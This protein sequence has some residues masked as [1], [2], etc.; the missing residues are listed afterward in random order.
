[1]TPSLNNFLTFFFFSLFVSRCMIGTLAL[2]GW[3]GSVPFR[4][5]EDWHPVVQLCLLESFHSELQGLLLS[6]KW[7]RHN[8][9]LW[10]VLTWLIFVR[11]CYLNS[12]REGLIYVSSYTYAGLSLT[13]TALSYVFYLPLGSALSVCYHTSPSMVSSSNRFC[14]ATEIL[15]LE[16]FFA[17]SPKSFYG[18]PLT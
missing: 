17:A 13:N 11:S 14:H 10:L 2:A 1:M 4:G 7:G 8:T 18:P 6:L 15:F 16:L 5:Q 9:K 12:F 3:V